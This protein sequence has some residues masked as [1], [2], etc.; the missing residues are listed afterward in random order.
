MYLVGFVVLSPRVPE[1][2]EP[3]YGVTVGMCKEVL[4]AV[5]TDLCRAKLVFGS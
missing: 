2:N 3:P 4:Q 5:H 1:R